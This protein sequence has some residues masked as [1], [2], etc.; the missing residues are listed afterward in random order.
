[1]SFPVV[2]YLFFFLSLLAAMAMIVE[3]SLIIFEKKQITPLPTRIL[4][5][6]SALVIGKDKSSRQFMGRTSAKDL[7]AYALCVLFFG[8]AVLVSSFV[9]LFTT[10][11]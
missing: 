3:G 8:A 7:R 10:L 9:Y 6:L 11:L 4:V 1:M 5:R 2:N